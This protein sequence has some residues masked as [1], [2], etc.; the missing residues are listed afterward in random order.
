MSTWTPP[1]CIKVRDLREGMMYEAENG[2]LYRVDEIR[3]QHES[4]FITWTAE[5][6]K[7]TE[8]HMSRAFQP[9]SEW[10]VKPHLHV[11]EEAITFI[12]S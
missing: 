2:D 1:Y 10:G 12:T 9:E 8:Y 4:Y 5:V 11:I 3:K 7:S 6:G